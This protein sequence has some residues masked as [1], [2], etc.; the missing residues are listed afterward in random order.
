MLRKNIK[1]LGKTGLDIFF[2]RV[3]GL[4][5]EAY[6]FTDQRTADA[7]DKFGLPKSAERLKELLDEKWEELDQEDKAADHDEAQRRRA[8]VQVL[9]RA[10]GADLESNID[11]VKAN[12][13]KLASSTSVRQDAKEEQPSHQ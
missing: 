13:F 4:W 7:L 6:P 3:Q 1:G 5:E 9:E 12:A 8:F 2:R 10:V 11:A